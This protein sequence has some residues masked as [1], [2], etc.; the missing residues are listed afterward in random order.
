MS[1]WSIYSCN[2]TRI[3]QAIQNI[4]WK[5]TWAQI[6]FWPQN[7][8]TNF[9]RNS[10]EYRMKPSIDF[11]K[12]MCQIKNEI[13]IYFTF[14]WCNFR[15]YSVPYMKSMGVEKKS[16]NEHFLLQNLC[17]TSNQW[18]SEHCIPNQNSQKICF[19]IDRQNIVGRSINMHTLLDR[20]AAATNSGP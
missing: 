6:L 18:R 8:H 4:L 7:Q 9:I 10:I 17:R 2:N 16:S 1:I 20:I 19:N 3:E 13:K 14:C 5:I 11:K 12:K 15:W